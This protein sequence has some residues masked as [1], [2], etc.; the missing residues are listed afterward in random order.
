[1]SISYIINKN[2]I[3]DIAKY[4][5]LKNF[6]EKNIDTIIR[7]RYYKNL[8]TN[9][10]GEDKPDSTYL[11]DDD[12]YSFFQGNDQYD[13]TNVPNH[14]KK[15]LDSLF[16]SLSE[17]EIT[18]FE[19][20]KDRKITIELKCERFENGLALLHTLIWNTTS[21]NNF[22]YQKDTVLLNKCIYRIRLTELGR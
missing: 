14:L 16:Y 2:G 5:N 1:M 3:Q 20:C 11:S 21:N 4:E 15:K 17:K 19:V 12:C 8:V 7:F 9:S 22:A 13:I 10:R 18:S 6:L